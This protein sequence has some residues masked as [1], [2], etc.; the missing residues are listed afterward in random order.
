MKHCPTCRR[1]YTDETVKF[2]RVDGAV[3]ISDSSATAGFAPTL[4]F[5]AAAKSAEVSTQSLQAVPSIAVLPF[6][7]MSA[8]PENEYF[9]DGLAEELIGALTKIENLRVVARTS[10]FSFKGK[11]A[12][13]REVGHKLNVTTVLEGSVRKA[14]NKLRITA[15][16]VDVSDGFHLWSERYDRQLAD[17][18]DI[19]EEISLAIVAALKIKLLGDEQADL[20]KRGTNDTEAYQLYLKGRFFWN[21]RTEEAL[22][23]G[24]EYFNRAIEHD[25]GYAAAYAGLSDS[26]ALLALRGLIPPKE[27]LPRAKAAAHKALEIDDSLAEAHASLAHVKLHDWDWPG[28]EEQFKRALELN[29]GHAIAYH[30]YSEYLMAMGR[31]DEAIERAKQAKE[32]DPLS[33]V[34]SST[35]A[36]ALYFARRYDQAIESL[37]QALELD[38]NHFALHFRLGLAYVLKG[39]N[40]EAIEAMQA[41]V[42]LSGRSTETLAGLGQAYAA[43]GMKTETQTVLYELNELSKERY[44]SPYSVA[45]IY[46]VVGEKDQAF[47][48]LEKAYEERHPDFIELKAEPLL[49]S[50]RSDPRFAD[51]LRR[52]GWAP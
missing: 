45:K 49:D 15:Q 38:P 21:K 41:S 19:Q 47:A 9:C 46:S 14:G 5:S 43:A 20:L 40:E 48:H 27:G 8:D 23:K 50:L 1:S 12:D 3:L 51:L 42:N 33:S 37:K 30:W 28:L 6:L 29:P 35:L 39:M 36:L 52:V 34:I 13:V 26:Y 11:Q 32:I 10:A 22:R 7:N 31:S 16:M 17:I 25:P 4:T 44:V 18:F 24:I 2:C